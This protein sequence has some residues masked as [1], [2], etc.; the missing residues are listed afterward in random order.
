MKKKALLVEDDRANAEVMKME[1][2]FLGYDVVVA[3]NG[4]DAITLARAEKPD[5]IVLDILLPK[6]DGLEAAV[7]IRLDPEIQRVP[8]LAAT[9][10]AAPGDRER[11]LQ[12]GCDGY[13][14]KP[15]TYKELGI[16]LDRLL[17]KRD[18]KPVS[19]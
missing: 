2:D 6:M 19:P 3:Y 7:E 1:L 10:L 14:A 18:G 12:G 17:D 11:C 5:V 8:I 4:P 15:F 9:A 16:A 13:L